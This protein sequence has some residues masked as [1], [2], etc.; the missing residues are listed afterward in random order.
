MFPGMA[1]I[2]STLDRMDHKGNPRK[3]DGRIKKKNLTFTGK[4][5]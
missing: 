4:A 1:G 5:R 3:R 2:I